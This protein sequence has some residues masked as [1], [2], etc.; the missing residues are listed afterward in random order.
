MTKITNPTTIN[1]S[2]IT[3]DEHQASEITGF[4]VKTLQQR[5]WAGKAPRFLKVGRKI[6]YRESDL[7]DFLDNSTV[8][9]RNEL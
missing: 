7:L 8:I 9:P 1:S 5:R 2:L 6:R 4:T 3:Y